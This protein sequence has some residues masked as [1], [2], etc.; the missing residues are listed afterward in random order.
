MFTSWSLRKKLIVAFSTS[1][2]TLVAVGGFGFYQLNLVATNYD[3]IA[4]TNFVKIDE[5]GAFRSNS[6]ELTWAMGRL[7][8]PTLAKEEVPELIKA[9]EKTTK[10]I[11]ETSANFLKLEYADGEQDMWKNVVGPRD[12]VVSLARQMLKLA[13]TPEKTQ[14]ERANLLKAFMPISLALRDNAFALVK[15]QR[16]E[17]AI[18]RA[19]AEFQARRAVI[20]VGCAVAFGT[21]LALILGITL[22]SSISN[23]LVKLVSEISAEAESVAAEA[24]KLSSTSESLSSSATEQA[25]ALQETAAST[26]QISAMIKKSAESASDAKTLTRLSH[27][28][29]GKGKSTVDEMSRSISE[30]DASN[31]D[32]AEVVKVIADIETKTQVINDIVIKTQLLSFNASVEA[33]RAGEHGKGF[34]VVAEEVGKLAQL[35]GSAAAEITALLES[36]LTRVRGLIATNQEKVSSGLD[37]SHRC[38]SVLDQVVKNINDVSLLS[39]ETERATLEQSRG[40]AEITKAMAQLDQVTQRNAQASLGAATSSEQ[41]AEQASRLQN[42]VVELERLALG[43]KEEKF[44]A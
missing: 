8:L 25:A 15:F 3:H 30:I 9:F 41:L 27:E 43:N 26:E 6:Y 7:G 19:A 38:G 44:A 21:L 31:R 11:S 12:E 2:L 14:I 1:A 5:L 40:V 16:K 13:E 20:G 32:I 4:D 39:E 29:A 22:S 23:L 17:A 36:S 18:W 28:T 34:S 35:S 42:A 24:A 33:A 37:V 10:R